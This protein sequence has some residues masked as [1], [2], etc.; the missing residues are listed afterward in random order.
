MN[1]SWAKIDSFIGNHTL[2]AL[3]SNRSCPAC[4]GD[5]TSSLLELAGFQ[6]FSDSSDVPKRTTVQIKQC[7]SCFTIYLNPCYSKYGFSILFS[8][9]GQSYGASE[10]RPN[11]QIE[12]LASRG[13]LK[14]GIRVLDVGCYRGHFLAKL[15]DSIKKVGVDIDHT[16]IE[17]GLKT[18]KEKNIEFVLD[19]FARFQ[20]DMDIDT[21][22]MFHVLEHLS[23]PV[24]VLKNLRT[25]SHAETRMV[26][27]V[28]IL[29]NG[30]T[31]DINGFFSVQH[32]T[33]FSRRSLNNCLLRAGWKIEEWFE[34]PDYNGCRVL[35]KRGDAIDEVVGDRRDIS[36]V[37]NYF[38]KWYGAIADIDIRL[39]T[40]DDNCRCII[41]GA[42][43]HTEFLYHL[44]SLFRGNETD[45][46][47]VDSDPLKHGKS[48]R[49]IGIHQPQILSDVDWTN[50]RLVVSSYG[51][52]RVIVNNC[53]ELGVP[54]E[55]I[56]KLYDKVHVY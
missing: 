50:T 41:W 37:L 15:P 2:P 27:E 18:Y 1:I 4:D 10:G 17:Y 13:L 53:K 19:D 33:H 52:Q 46:A 20:Y 23:N 29:E 16:A 43:L 5:D 36:T 6:F 21:I 44:T 38:S 55:Q 8:E 51:S 26:I 31:N 11:E 28:P 7:K 42:G 22:T 32:M 3:T 34:Q 39:N 40:V 47:I 48:W 35:V 54:E 30:F 45:F 56:I 9:A 12:W 14:S 24:K 49:G 25:K